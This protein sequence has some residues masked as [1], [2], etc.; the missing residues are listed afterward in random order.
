[1]TAALIIVCMAAT[2]A[3][4]A[5]YMG[6][7]W[8]LLRFLNPADSEQ[9]V[10]LE[11]GAYVVD[12]TAANEN[13]TLE[14]KQILGD[15][16]L[17]YIL[18]DFTAPEGTVLNADRYRFQLSLLHGNP[19]S[20]SAGYDYTLLDDENAN[21][22][23]I[24]LVLTYLSDNIIAGRPV[25]MRVSDLEAADAYP[26]KFE[27]VIPGSWETKF[28]MKYKD[29]SATR[30]VQQK[31]SLYGY[32]ATLS[33]I[34]ISPISVTL[35]VNSENTKAISEAARNSSKEIGPNETSD[36]YPITIHYQDGTSET[37]TI[38][39]GMNRADFLSNSI[40]IIKTFTPIIKD[41][42]IASVEFFD[43]VIP[44]EEHL[45]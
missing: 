17:I 14:V 22:N 5:A 41:K 20:N 1:M 18:M 9:E 24:S 7:D 45:Q 12:E 26:G 4:A 3:Y 15:S 19:G 27:T 13:G 16:N 38:F 37:T 30:L 8:K 36:G 39:T 10:Y 23:K 2:T 25:T 32:E 6:L 21:D 29:L 40:T 31:L 33:S 42:E 28:D 34:S 35:K 11:N 43:A 44:V